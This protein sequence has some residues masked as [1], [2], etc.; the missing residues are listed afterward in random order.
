MAGFFGVFPQPLLATLLRDYNVSK[1]VISHNEVRVLQHLQVRACEAG[2]VSPSHIAEI[3]SLSGI[4][5]NE[6]V[7]RA[8]Y[9]LEGKS[10]VEPEPAGD[11]TSNHWKITS[12]GI[13]AY[14]ILAT[15]Q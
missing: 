4:K 8:L 13:K 11:L 5:N 6:E 14:E 7:Q 12:M 1:P 15:G 2:T 3:S 10:L 9:I